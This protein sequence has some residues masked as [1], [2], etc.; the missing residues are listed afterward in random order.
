MIM[1]LTGANRCLDK[2]GIWIR[3]GI[4]PAGKV[5]M[6]TLPANSLVQHLASPVNLT[7][8]VR[9]TPYARRAI[10][11]D[12]HIIPEGSQIQ[13]DFS[14]ATELLFFSFDRQH[15]N[16]ICHD[17]GQNGDLDLK[18]HFSLRDQQMSSLVHALQEELRSGCARGDSYMKYLSSTLIRY[19]TSTYSAHAP[20]PARGLSGLPP[21]RLRFILDHIHTNIH[22][23][24]FSRDLAKLVQMSPQHFG[25]LFRQS[26]G[27]APYEYILCERIEQGKR[28]LA[29]TQMPIMDIAIEVGFAHHSHFGDAFR[30]LTGM[31][32]K[33]YRQL[34]ESFNTPARMNCN[35]AA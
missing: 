23:R 22:T 17:L 10:P 19:V 30:H 21:N 35:E 27:R 9:G 15:L 28:L 6:W 5:P 33:Q 8:I 18:F 12:L 16:S 34:Y 1:L 11:G 7:C 14:G 13:L 26:T 32:P 4:Q 3:Q 29:E 25:N 24:L 2:E 20:A 31:T